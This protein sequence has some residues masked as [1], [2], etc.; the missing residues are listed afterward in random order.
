MGQT[1]RYGLRFP[2]PSDPAEAWTA[3]K[4]LADDVERIME[5]TQ[6]TITPAAGWADYGLDWPI[7]ARSVAGR[8]LRLS[9]LLKR[10]GAPLTTNST[11]Y[12]PIA[13]VGVTPT[14]AVVGLGMASTGLIRWQIGRDGTVG[15][16]SAPGQAAVTITTNAFLSL[17]GMNGRV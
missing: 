10:T 14:W 6:V 12:Q 4:N 8:Q 9:G 15:I 11:T 2:E 16:M 17:D 1:T 3:L 7:Y 5:G 13:T